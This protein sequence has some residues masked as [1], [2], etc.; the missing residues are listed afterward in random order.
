MNAENSDSLL[1]TRGIFSDEADWMCLQAVTSSLTCS[2]AKLSEICFNP[3][4]SA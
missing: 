1:C 2:R 3:E 4:L